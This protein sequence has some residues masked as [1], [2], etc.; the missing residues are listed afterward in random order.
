[1][2]SGGHSIP[3]TITTTNFGIWHWKGLK[4]NKRNNELKLWKS[5]EEKQNQS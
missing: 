5:K 2:F 4:K 3:V 1:L